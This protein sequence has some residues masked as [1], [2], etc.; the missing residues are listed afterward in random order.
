MLDHMSILVRIIGSARRNR[1]LAN[2]IPAA[3]EIMQRRNSDYWLP[4]M[5]HYN[6]VNNTRRPER[7]PPGSAI[8][9]P[10]EEAQSGGQGQTW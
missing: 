9:V 10:F 8:C 1:K 7:S 2:H 3:Q 5:G 6:T 4:Q